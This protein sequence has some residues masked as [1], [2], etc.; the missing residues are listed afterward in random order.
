MAFQ[1]LLWVGV[2]LLVL[3]TLTLT[4]T[5]ILPIHVALSWQSDPAKPSTVLL[6]LFGG[7]TPAIKVYDSSKPSKP[8][9][10]AADKAPKRRKE[11]GRG[12]VPKGDVLSEGMALLRRLVGAVHIDTLWLDAEVGLGDPA[13]TGQLYGQLCPLIYATEG[14]VLVRP[15]FEAACLQGSALARLHF[16]PLGLIWP[17]ARFGWRMFGPVR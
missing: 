13:E 12:W 11:R 8:K 15:N 6:R 16:A 14:H 1:I 5:L 7:V 17:F 10:K 2:A 9:K 4:L 3:I